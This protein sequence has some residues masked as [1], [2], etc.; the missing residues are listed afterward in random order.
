MHTD[1]RESVA[2][3]A[4][5]GAEIATQAAELQKELDKALI[6]ALKELARQ[7]ERLVEIYTS[8][9]PVD[10]DLEE[11]M[12][13]GFARM[14]ADEAEIGKGI[15]QILAL[16]KRIRE[17]E[18]EIDETTDD[19]RRAAL[20]SLRLSD[21]LEKNLLILEITLRAREALKLIA[22]LMRRLTTI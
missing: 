10:N 20:E 1:S 6:D 7:S 22:R 5:D 8:M 17:H 4:D 21:L 13:R 3:K 15:D 11:I 9:L 18:R 16:K 14:E 19:K 12:T 2:R